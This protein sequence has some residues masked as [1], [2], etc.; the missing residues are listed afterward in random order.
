MSLAC[1]SVLYYWFALVRWGAEGITR[2]QEQSK[3]VGRLRKGELALLL[4]Y[5]V[6]YLI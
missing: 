6:G 1:P 2:L 4:L 3:G 5:G